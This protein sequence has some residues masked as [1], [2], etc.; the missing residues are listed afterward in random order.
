MVVVAK[1]MEREHTATRLSVSSGVINPCGSSMD[2][3][4]FGGSKHPPQDD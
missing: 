3:R 4:L 1:I 2:H